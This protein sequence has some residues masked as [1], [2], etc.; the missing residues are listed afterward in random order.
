MR[1]GFPSL[2]KAAGTCSDHVNQINMWSDLS[3]VV[4][5]RILAEDSKSQVFPFLVNSMGKYFRLTHFLYS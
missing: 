5:R 3:R 1:A 2:C 4:I